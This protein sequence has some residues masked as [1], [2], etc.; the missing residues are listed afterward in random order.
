M[1]AHKITITCLRKEW[2]KKFWQ[3]LLFEKNFAAKL[4]IC[5]GRLLLDQNFSSK[6]KQKYYRM[7]RLKMALKFWL[8]CLEELFKNLKS[9]CD[10]GRPTYLWRSGF[11]FT[12]IL[13]AAFTCA[14]PKSSKRHWWLVTVFLRF[15]DLGMFLSCS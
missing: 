5:I 1:S 8:N 9:K 6:T 13:Q 4:L 15:W 3:Q 7:S 11:N 2:R 10:S 14:D 12:N